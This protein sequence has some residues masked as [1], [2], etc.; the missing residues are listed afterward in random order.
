MLNKNA[1]RIIKLALL[2]CDES[3]CILISLNLK[4]NESLRLNVHSNFFEESMGVGKILR[5]IYLFIYLFTCLINLF[6]LN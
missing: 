2:E 3:K 6:S 4:R 5:D 1:C